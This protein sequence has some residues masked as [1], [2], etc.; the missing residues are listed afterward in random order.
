MRNYVKKYRLAAKLTLSDLAE[1][2]GVPIST[3]AD[4][5]HG[6]EPRVVTALMIA[7]ALRVPV[8]RLWIP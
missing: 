8:E 7:R 4:I 6:A 3:I 2:S 1:R 5:E